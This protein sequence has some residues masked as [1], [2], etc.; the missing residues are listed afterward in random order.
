MAADIRH[1][2][3]FAFKLMAMLLTCLLPAGAFAHD[4]QMAIASSEPGGGV[5]LLHFDAN[6]RLRTTLIDSERG[7]NTYRSTELGFAAQLEIDVANSLYPVAEGNTLRIQIFSVDAG[8]WMRIDGRKLDEVGES[9]PI[10]T[11]PNIHNHPEWLLTLPEHVAGDFS[12]SFRLLSRTPMYN[13][14]GVYVVTLTNLPIDGE[15][16]PTAT[17]PPLEEWTAT[18]TA[19]AS[20]TVSP[21]EAFVPPPSPTPTRPRIRPATTTPTEIEASP[22]ELEATPTETEAID[23]SPTP[24]ETLI[25][26]AMADDPNCDGRMSAA[27]IAA[28]MLQHGPSALSCSADA[29]G[30]GGIDQADLQMVVGDLFTFKVRRPR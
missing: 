8:A 27:D 22:T 1:T 18:A 15:E 3:I 25:P 12:I 26:D 19:T 20:A 4:G 24:T 6:A 29:N 16:E 30:D 21:T 28:I 9:V 23:P 11:T 17:L 10:G 13:D 14:S 2:S 7:I 5:L